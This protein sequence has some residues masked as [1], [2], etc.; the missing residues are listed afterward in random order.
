[1]A[2][3]LHRPAITGA[4]LDFSAF[5]ASGARHVLSFICGCGNTVVKIP[6]AFGQALSMAYIEP[7]SISKNPRFGA[8]PEDY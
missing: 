1:M 7:W 6:T 2:D 5:V 8:R 3:I 4:T